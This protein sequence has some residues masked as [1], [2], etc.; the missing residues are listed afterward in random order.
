MSKPLSLLLIAP[1]VEPP[2]EG[3]NK[4]TGRRWANVVVGGQASD[5]PGTCIGVTSDRSF[6]SPHQR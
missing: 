1:I 5:G 2:R 3:I 6:L 4:R